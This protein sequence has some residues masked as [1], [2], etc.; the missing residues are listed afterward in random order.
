MLNQRQKL[1]QR[2][3]RY[4]NLSKLQREEI[5][6]GCGGKGGIVKPP[7]ATFFEEECNWHDFNYFLGYD[8]TARLKADKQLL[9]A[10]LKKVNKLGWL[11]RLRYKPWCY[12]YY[13]AVRI[14]GKKFFY[15]SNKEQ[16]VPE[17]N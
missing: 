5:C 9:E 16:E 14:V 7:H 10:M 2:S 4:R 13:R 3:V 8:A 17:I 15:Y 12:L 6:N 11:N 1:N